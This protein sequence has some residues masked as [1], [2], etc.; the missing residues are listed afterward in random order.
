[1]ELKGKTAL[2]TGGIHR[3]GSAIVK[4][5]S[6]KG[7]YVA[8]HSRQAEKNSFQADLNQPGSAKKLAR[9]VEEKFGPIQI[10]INNAAIFE[11]TPFL[12]ITEEDWD[13][14]LNINLKAPF[15]LSQA[16]ARGML[17]KKEGRIINIADYTAV[18]P[19]KDYLPY[20]ISKAGLVSLTKALALELAP[21]VLVNALSLGPILPPSDYSE[22]KIGGAANKTLLKRWG[23]VEEVAKTVLFL[24]ETCDFATGSVFALDG[25]RLLG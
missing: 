8:V 20:T 18:K 10:L 9:D 11:K 15:L 14:H 23:N 4:A 24:L 12:E 19:S 6:E 22:E 17:E 13:R 16:V 21:H 1:M 7:V 2:V 3:I 5:L 25:G